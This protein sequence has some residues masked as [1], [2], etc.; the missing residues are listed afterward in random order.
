M[1]RLCAAFIL[2]T[3]G[4]TASSQIFE[5]TLQQFSSEFISERI[6]FHFDKTSYTAGDTVWFKAYLMKGI[7]PETNSKTLYVDWTGSDGK[8]IRRTTWPIVDGITFGQFEI[9]SNLKFNAIEVRAYTKWMLNFDSSFLFSRNL[10]ILTGD[11]STA[12]R[13]VVPQIHFF[14][15]GGNMV[16]GLTSKVAFKATDQYGNPL[17]ITGTLLEGDEIITDVASMHDGMGYFFL[18]PKPGRQYT[19]RWKDPSE[20]IHQTSLPQVKKTGVIMKVVLTNDRRIFYVQAKDKTI[21]ESV[22]IIGTMYSKVVFDIERNL[23]DGVTQAAIPVADLPS[24]ILVITVLNERN[25]PLAERIT[26]I[27]NNEYSFSPNIN[28][29]NQ[30]LD[31]RGRNEIE[32]EIPDSLEANLSI[33]VTDAAIDFNNTHTIASDLLLSSEIK[34]KIH[35][36]E[37]YFRNNDDS[38]SNYLDLVMLTNGWRKIK[39]EDIAT[40]KLPEIKYPADTALITI[41]GIVEG[42]RQNST[43]DSS[44][45][46]MVISKKDSKEF[47]ITPIRPDGSFKMEDYILIDTATIYYQL[48][49][50]KNMKKAS[51]KFYRNTDPKPPVNTSQI[52]TPLLADTTGAFRHMQLANEIA[53]ILAMAQ[54]KILEEVKVTAKPKSDIEIMDEKYTTGLFS[55]GA[56]YNFDLVHIK[57]AAG[58]RSIF[59]YLQSRVPG[60]NFV[61]ADP[62]RISW[63]GG[64][65][66]LF[67]DEILVDIEIMMTVPVTNIAYVKAIHPPFNGVASAGANGA[68]AVYTRRGDDDPGF[69]R[70]KG[71]PNNTIP[72]YSKIREFFS[73]DYSTENDVD[74]SDIRTTIYW[75]PEVI[76]KGDNK[77]VTLSFYNSD[78]AKS[79]RIVIEG[80]TKTGQMTRIVR[81]IKKETD[82]TGSL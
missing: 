1:K 42:V 24:G 20:A 37:F 26:F 41:E 80:I 34:G 25:L 45:V 48:P 17:E 21:A 16:E 9:P 5:N 30:N 72:G 22:R 74:I 14:P 39:W 15:E 6:H 28:W 40:G 35:N 33:S 56:S 2:L 8:I 69:D 62:P 58:Y 75:N 51:I 67:L 65:P 44:N 79:F 31:K 61:D 76:L 63:R 53:G 43:I 77:K 49:R 66:S 71:L 36:P 29:K 78:V 81:T 3:I 12:A 50:E 7:T 54:G 47:A 46:I 38:T 11:K 55:G 27:N 64:A 68:I 18:Q 4:N 13:R 19:L 82:K 10:N 60:F 23:T 59:N 52:I 57:T 73:P 70:G 32:I